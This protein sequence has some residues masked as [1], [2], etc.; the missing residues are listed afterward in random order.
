MNLIHQFL[1]QKTFFVELDDESFE[2]R[3]QLS[4]QIFQMA[5]FGK[6]SPEYSSFLEVE[7][8]NY[9]YNLLTEQLEKERE[10]REKEEAKIK[11]QSARVRSR[12]P[13]RPRR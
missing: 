2:I 1:S 12:I 10:E 13:T 3:R 7:E 11:S 9:M 6:I 4:K 5:Y 8:R